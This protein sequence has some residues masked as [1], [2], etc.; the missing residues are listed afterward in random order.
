[1][2]N[3]PAVSLKTHYLVLYNTISAFFWFAVLLRVLLIMP[4]LGPENV[5]GGVCDFARYVQTGA[6]LEI[7]HSA[8]GLVRSP[9]FTTVMQ[10][11]S[12]LLLTWGVTWLFPRSGAKTLAFSTMLIC[13]SITEIIRYSFYASSLR[14]SP[15]KWLVWL[16]YNTFFVLY[17][18]GVS[19]ELLVIYASLTDAKKLSPLYYY[20]L[21]VI[22]LTYIPGFYTLFTH[23]MKQ[24][25]RIMKNMGKRREI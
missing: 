8:I 12:R 3:K 2:H 14:G 16:R 10:V 17:P 21:I 24:R 23:M 5:A 22:V 7:V 15:S 4:I 11:F 25:R 13:W 20:F 1:M 9:I 18:A 19:S 6:V